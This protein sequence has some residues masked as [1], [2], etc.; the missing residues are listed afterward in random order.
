MIA[1]KLFKNLINSLSGI[2]YAL[3]DKSFFLECAL[4]I[5]LIPFILLHPNCNKFHKAAIL[6]VY[7]L[8]LAF[9]LLNTS[10]EKLC[11]RINLQYDEDI[12]EIKDIAS[13][14]V[15]LMLII[16]IGLIILIYI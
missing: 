3:A 6:A 2:R 4:G 8:L 15:F 12:K 5:F 10:I 13:A 9:E 14:A 1:T 11:N 7:L 16:L